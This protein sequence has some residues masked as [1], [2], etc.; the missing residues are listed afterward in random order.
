MINSGLVGHS[1]GQGLG[2]FILRRAHMDPPLLA[3][4]FC[5]MLLGAF[6]LYSAS[7]SDLDMLYRQ[8]VR[9]GLALGTVVASRDPLG[10]LQQRVFL[11]DLIV[12]F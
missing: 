3:G 9:V 11:H 4:I 8:A 10:Q 5:V 6:V 7:G 2:S 12:V 1:S